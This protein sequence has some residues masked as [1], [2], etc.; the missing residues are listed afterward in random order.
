MIRAQYE[1]QKKKTDELLTNAEQHVK[2]QV[3]NAELIKNAQVELEKKEHLLQ[4]KES[5]IEEWVQFTKFIFLFILNIKNVNRQDAIILFA[6]NNL[7]TVIK[8]V[9]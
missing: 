8:F 6:K 2:E 4:L 1:E 3:K 9:S 5:E 7:S